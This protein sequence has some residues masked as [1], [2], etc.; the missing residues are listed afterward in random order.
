MTTI[1]S[2]SIVAGVV[3]VYSCSLMKSLGLF[4]GMFSLLFVSF[5]F[6]PFVRA[7]LTSSLLPRRLFLLPLTAGRFSFY[8]ALMYHSRML[9]AAKEISNL[10]EFVYLA[11]EISRMLNEE[12]GGVA[13]RGVAGPSR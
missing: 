2:H 3:S 10:N 12:V 5:R 11:K 8:R 4:V 13:W 1:S 9:R 7:P 6:V